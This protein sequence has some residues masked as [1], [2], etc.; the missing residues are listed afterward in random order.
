MA[1]GQFISFEGID[2]SGK[3]TQARALAQRL[4]AMGAEVVLTREP[5]GSPGAE[6]IRSLL[7]TGDPGRWSAETE[8]LLFTAARR[9]H[10]ERV[11]EPAL[12]RGQTVI[13]DRF[14]DST[15]VYQGATRGDLRDVVDRLHGLMIGREP[16][17]TFI[18]DMDP[19]VALNR[20]L[21][22]KSGEDRFEDFG[23]GF[24][25]TL[26]HGFLALARSQSDR[27]IIIDGNRPEAEV[28]AEIAA[29][30]QARMSQ[31]V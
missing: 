5:G 19:A 22:R 18:I 7:L 30:V 16:E 15:R 4:G 13:T 23:L 14:A 11:I 1:S 12:A 6:E 20:G 25:E 8:I 24:Q 29:Q 2:G 21:A 3:S 9:D 17:L 28:A 27:C 26:R 10:L 31:V